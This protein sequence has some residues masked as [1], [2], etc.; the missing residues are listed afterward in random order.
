MTEQNI[1]TIL[2][3][4]K[5]TVKI[6]FTA[7]QRLDDEQ[8]KILADKYYH[9]D[10]EANYSNF[11]GRCTTVIPNTDKEMADRYGITQ[12][13]YTKLR[14]RAESDLSYIYSLVED[15]LKEKQS[16]L[17]DKFVFKM[18]DLYVK[19]DR[20]VNYDEILMTTD[21]E[22]AKVFHADTCH[23]SALDTWKYERVMTYQ[24]KRLFE[25]ESSF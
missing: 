8:R 20:L 17:L 5:E 11:I 1:Q 23:L 19:E 4:E 12:K 21:H 24:D 3:H 13:E 7:L 18:G 10:R 22:Q 9:S 14:I 15:E 25:L 16:K 2:G 6:F